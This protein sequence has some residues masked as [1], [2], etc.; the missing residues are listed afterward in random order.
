MSVSSPGGECSVTLTE[1]PSLKP[2]I[3]LTG[4]NVFIGYET[5]RELVADKLER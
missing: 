5:F 4:L 3:M 1:S 2:P